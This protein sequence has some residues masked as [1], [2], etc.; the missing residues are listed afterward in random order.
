MNKAANFVDS[1]T[2]QWATNG[3]SW[4][5][6]F[7][8]FF[9]KRNCASITAIISTMQRPKHKQSGRHGNTHQKP[10]KS[11]GSSNEWRLS[12]SLCRDRNSQC[13]ASALQIR[14][15]DRI[16]FAASGSRDGAVLLF[17]LYISRH[18]AFISDT[19]WRLFKKL[20]PLGFE[21]DHYSSRHAVSELLPF[22]LS[23]FLLAA[24]RA[25]QQKRPKRMRP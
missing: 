4:L 22:F 10:R 12:W 11:E 1:L 14:S 2:N 9:F 20:F 21:R 18:R 25:Q 6:S 7:F 15:A 8:P 3:S 16:L 13:C 5:F 24:V 19:L 17:D 23:L